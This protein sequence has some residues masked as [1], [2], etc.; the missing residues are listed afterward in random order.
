MSLFDH[1]EPEEF[2]LFIYNFNMT[3]IET[4]P[5]E[6][7][8]KIQYLCTLV[9]G[10]AFHHFDLLFADVENTETINVDYHIKGLALYFTL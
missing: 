7:D 8:A 2:L 1:G 10:E 9:L 4:G 6:M 3:L 5:L